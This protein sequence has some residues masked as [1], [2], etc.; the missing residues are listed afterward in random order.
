M[1]LAL[2]AAVCGGIF[3]EIYYFPYKD[4]KGPLFSV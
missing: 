3:Y 2:Q 1:S 4:L